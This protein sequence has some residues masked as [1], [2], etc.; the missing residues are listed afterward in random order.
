M[1][2]NH[3]ELATTGIVPESMSVCD[4]NQRLYETLKGMGLHVDAVPRE[5]HPE[6]IDHIIVSSVAPG[7]PLDYGRR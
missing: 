5:D 3:Q 2:S 6:M 4:R 7:C 1:S